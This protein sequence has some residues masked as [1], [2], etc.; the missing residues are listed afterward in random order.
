MLDVAEICCASYCK[1]LPCC[2]PPRFAGC[3]EK[4][5]VGVGVVGQE[6]LTLLCHCH[7]FILM[8]I[9]RVPLCNILD[10]TVRLYVVP[11]MFVFSSFSCLTFR[12][13]SGSTSSCPLWMLFETES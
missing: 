8:P 12:V 2:L 3:C 1:Y 11:R 5:E 10:P 9:C 7:P 6:T 4:K 13:C